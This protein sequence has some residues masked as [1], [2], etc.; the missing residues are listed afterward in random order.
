VSRAAVGDLMEVEGISERVA[1]LVYDHFHD[2]G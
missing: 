2:N 1:R